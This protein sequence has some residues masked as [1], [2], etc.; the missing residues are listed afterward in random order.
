MKNYY[1]DTRYRNLKRFEKYLLLALEIKSEL[2]SEMTIHL[3]ELDSLLEKIE[4]LETLLNREV[5]L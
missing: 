3:T 1:N 4:R 2:P 5:K